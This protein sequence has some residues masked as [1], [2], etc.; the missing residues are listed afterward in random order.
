MPV[1]PATV[2]FMGGIDYSGSSKGQ[3]EWN[4]FYKLKEKK[5]CPFEARKKAIQNGVPGFI[6]VLNVQLYLVFIGTPA[7]RVN[8][9]LSLRAEWWIHISR[10]T[11]FTRYALSLFFTFQSHEAHDCKIF[12]V[13]CGK[14]GKCGRE[15]ILR[16]EVTITSL[17]KSFSHMTVYLDHAIPWQRF[18]WLHDKTEVSAAPFSYFNASIRLF[19]SVIQY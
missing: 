7:F 17:V 8:T 16:G 3:C 11:F 18:C 5:V 19:Q 9:I 2:F 4:A 14:C 13:Q 1:S 15:G 6:T 10:L 12:P